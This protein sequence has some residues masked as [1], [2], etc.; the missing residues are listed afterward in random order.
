M[1]EADRAHSRR[2]ASTAV[3]LRSISSKSIEA[4]S[5]GYADLVEVEPTGFIRRYPG[6]WET[7]P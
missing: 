1:I 3:F 5:F 6:L 2:Y 7:E 4:P